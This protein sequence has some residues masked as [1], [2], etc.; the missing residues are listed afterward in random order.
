MAQINLT[1]M[2]NSLHCQGHYTSNYYS[3]QCFMQ[4][5]S[6]WIVP[7]YTNHCSSYF[8]NICIAYIHTYMSAHLLVLKQNYLLILVW[9]ILQNF[10]NSIEILFDTFTREFMFEF[11]CSIKW[12]LNVEDL[13]AVRWQPSASIFLTLLLS[14]STLSITTFMDLIFFVLN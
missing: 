2:Q 12:I 3:N 5:M 10:V 13:L 9:W 11:N 7:I 6:I 14:I 8:I 4:I 1:H